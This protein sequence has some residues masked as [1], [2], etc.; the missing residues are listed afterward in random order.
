MPA[1]TRVG[2]ADIAHCGDST[3][4]D[5]SPDVFCNGKGV[6]RA[7]DSNTNHLMPRSGH[8]CRHHS[9][10][11]TSGSSTVFANGKGVGRV[12]DLITNC[13]SVAAGSPDTFAG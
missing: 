7:G 3:R 4:A 10:P 13:T 8:R 5:G 9:A 6:S 11:I 1:V 2:D 12:G